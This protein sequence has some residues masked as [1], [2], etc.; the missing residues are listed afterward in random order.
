MTITEEIRGKYLLLAFNGRL[1]ATWSDYVKENCLNHIRGGHHHLLI[2][3][4]N[5]SFLSS[6]GIR[7][8]VIIAK[9]LNTVGGSLTMV[10]AIPFVD[11]T[12]RMTGLG[13][14]LAAEYPAELQETPPVETLSSNAETEHYVLGDSFSM[15]MEIPARWRPWQTITGETLISQ[16]FPTNIMAIGIGSA[17]DTKEEALKS[18]GDFLAVAG[19]VVFCSPGDN[20]RPDYLIK[21]EE[22][23]PEMHVIQSIKLQGEWS[24]HFRFNTTETQTSFGISNLAE[25]GMQL[26]GG[27]TIAIL[28]IAE[29]HGLVG[30]SLAKSPGMAQGEDVAQYPEIREWVSFTGEPVFQKQ[31]GIICGVVSTRADAEKLLLKPLPSLPGFYG[32]FH[33]AVF[34]FQPLPNGKIEL[35]TSLHN[36]FHGP[37]PLAIMHLIDDQ[38]PLLGVGESSFIRGAGWCAQVNIKEDLS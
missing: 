4:E 12:L 26:T 1:D 23:T 22:Y 5:L 36:F 18:L 20:Q 8:L 32:H 27:D 24:H 3:A 15:Q 30:A 25:R 11:K 13:D 7:V 10:N 21:T 6:A 14:W 35:H 19:H 29:I 2:D 37:S 16:C 28:L 33:A 9:E 17:L 31:Q 38:R 34:P